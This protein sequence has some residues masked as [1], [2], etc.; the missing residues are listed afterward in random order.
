MAKLHIAMYPWYSFGHMIPYVHLANE[1][2]ARGHR[3][4][5]FVSK[6]AHSKL[7]SHNLHPHLITF[8]TIT[9]PKVDGLPEGTET[10]HD[11]PMELNHLLCDA[12]LL[13][14]QQVEE[15]LTADKPNFVFHD[16]AFWIP[17]VTKKLGI[18]SVCFL[19]ISATCMASGIKPFREV[20]DDKPLT[21]EELTTPPPGYP[22]ATV[23][24]TLDEIMSLL[25]ASDFSGMTKLHEGFTTSMSD[26]DVLAIRSCTELEGKFCDYIQAHYKKPLLL[27]GHVLPEE[28]ESK[29][30]Q[31]WADW[32][33][34]FEPGSVLYCAFGSQY[35]LEKDQFQELVLGFELTGLPFFIALKPPVGCT[36]IEEALPEGLEE[37]V[38]GRGVVHG[39]W[40][41]QTLFLSH[42][43]VG[44]FVSHCG[45]GSMWESLVSDKQIVLVPHLGDQI[46]NTRLLSTDLKVA[47]EVKR[48]K[49]RWFSKESLN[50][51]IK[52]VMDKDSEVA[53]LLKKNHLEL[54][55]KLIKPGFSSGYVDRF[56]QSLEELAN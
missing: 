48:E 51:A 40:V 8:I 2:A 35:V 10:G 52:S 21:E 45:F 17:Q 18:K 47:V 28:S 20:T 53:I 44:C 55:E 3:I 4:S 31:R 15:I 9:I 56:V 46:I 27:T 1:L 30:E 41:Q 16:L 39:G 24:L 22:S 26:C 19:V 34:G 13:T 5:I 14:R 33:Q 43:S 11:V 38:K 7:Q 36:N 23:V 32:L 42:P 29:L 37:R 50:E 12:M 49:N 6:K 25:G 54:R